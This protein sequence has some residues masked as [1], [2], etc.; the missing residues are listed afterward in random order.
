MLKAS[1]KPKNTTPYD[2]S[3]CRVEKFSYNGKQ[4]QITFSIPGHETDKRTHLQLKSFD[5]P[6]PDLGKALIAVQADLAN[7]TEVSMTKINTI[8][9]TEVR[10]KHKEENIGFKVIGFRA[11]GNARS[12]L[13]LDAP[14]KWIEHPDSKQKLGE[15]AVERLNTLIHEVSEY[16][17]GKRSQQSLFNG[18]QEKDQVDE[19]EPEKEAELV[20]A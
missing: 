12:P 20:E 9:V 2:L 3:R 8:T 15:D 16:V 5:S 14:L 19:V 6:H 18:S 4:I 13:K 10:L 11:I 17:N 7:L 1:S